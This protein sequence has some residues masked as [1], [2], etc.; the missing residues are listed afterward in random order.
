MRRITFA[1]GLLGAISVTAQ[2]HDHDH[3]HHQHNAPAHQH[4]LGHL[5]L[6]LEDELLLLEL[7][8]P[9]ED[10]LGFE[11]APRTTEQRA[12]V[13]ALRDTLQQPE[14]LFRLPAAARCDLETMELHSSLF[15]QADTQE[16]SDHHTL[17]EHAD[18][19][20]QYQF[21]CTAVAHLQH[22]DIV[23]FGQ[24]PGSETLQLQAITPRGQ[25]GD[26]L[27]ATHNRIRL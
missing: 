9:A 17:A 1:V 6:V 8:I 12:Q 2:T 19:R 15:T 3:G 16:E 5:D 11:H 24:F 25:Y 22:L 4:G 14:L 7:Q 18:I 20:A 26:E 23:L 21:R 27:N 10:L 13:Q